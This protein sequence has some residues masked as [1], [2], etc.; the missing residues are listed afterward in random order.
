MPRR[1]ATISP[2]D[3]EL[4]REENLSE[5]EDQANNV[6]ALD[7]LKSLIFLGRLQTTVNIGGFAFELSTLTAS[8]QK[9]VMS[10]IM[11][12]P[13]DGTNQRMLDIKPLTM[14]FAVSKINKV[15]LEDICDDDSLKDSVDRRVHVMMNLQSVVLEKLYREYDNLVTRSSKEVGIE[16]LKE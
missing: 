9:E 10:I 15:P 2:S 14:A 12:G 8:Q 3:Q 11:S 16:D 4:D 5:H 13:T 1:T 7:D 6:L